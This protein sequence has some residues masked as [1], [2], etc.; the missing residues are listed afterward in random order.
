MNRQWRTLRIPRGK[1]CNSWQE[2]C[3]FNQ[4]NGGCS[5]FRKGRE[6]GYDSSTIGEMWNRCAECQDR[7]PNGAK[8]KII[9]RCKEAK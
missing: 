1:R 3:P 2:W 7:F 6:I 8:I 4:N 9:P 5:L